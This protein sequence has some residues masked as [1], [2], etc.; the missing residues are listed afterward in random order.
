MLDDP[1]V[2][3]GGGGGEPGHHAA[4]DGHVLHARHQPLAVDVLFRII[5][6]AGIAQGV[7]R[8]AH[9]QLGLVPQQ[10]QGRP[11]LRGL[12]GPEDGH[13]GILLPRCVEHLAGDGL[14]VVQPGDRVP[15]AAAF[16]NPHRHCRQGHQGAVL[17]VVPVV[18]HVVVGDKGGS[19]LSRLAHAEGGAQRVVPVGVQRQNAH[20]AAAAL[21]GHRAGGGGARSRQEG[22]H[23]QCHCHQ[24]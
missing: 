19:G 4:G 18:D 13:V 7:H 2:A 1:G 22:H 15:G 10:G 12:R 20:H 21:G 17:G 16:Q 3:E 24:R 11:V 6:G 14:A 23:H 5:G 9:L 8:V